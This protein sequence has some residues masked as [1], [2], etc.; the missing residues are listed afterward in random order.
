MMCIAILTTPGTAVDKK[1]FRRC[2]W[3]NQHG[4]GMAYNNPRDASAVVIDKG[5]MTIDSAWKAYNRLADTVGKDSPMLLHF[6]AAT[7]GEKSVNNCH[8]FKVKGGA[9]IHNGTFFRDSTLKKSDTCVVAETMHNE[10]TYE[11][12]TKNKKEF[13]EAFGYNRVAFLYGNGKYVLFSE[14]YNSRNGQVGQWCDGI[15]YSNGGWKGE[16]NGYYG[17]G[18][19]KSAD[20]FSDFVDDDVGLAMLDAS[21]AAKI[22]V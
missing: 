12:L 14:H 10:L 16:Y 1:V 7:V 5:Y 4:F 8:P 9:M 13:D 2:W 15:W 11:N 17:N 19:K 6:R 22:G 20:Q 3:N 18:A 21:L